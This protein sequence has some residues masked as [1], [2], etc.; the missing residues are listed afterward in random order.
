MAKR[1][2]KEVY[3]DLFRAYSVANNKGQVS[4]YIQELI[5]LPNLNSSLQKDH[6]V[7][8]ASI[9]DSS[10]NTVLAGILRNRKKYEEIYKAFPKADAKIRDSLFKQAF[11]KDYVL[12]DFINN[13][14]SDKPKDL[15]TKLDWLKTNNI[16][17][18]TGTKA[19]DFVQKLTSLNEAEVKNVLKSLD[20]LTA[21]STGNYSKF[22]S[23]IAAEIDAGT[24]PAS[25]PAGKKG[26][27]R[28]P[29]YTIA[30][31]DDW[32]ND[33]RLKNYKLLSN[34]G[35][36]ILDATKN[37]E[38]IKAYIKAGLSDTSFVSKVIQDVG[39]VSLNKKKQLF[40]SLT[41]N[42]KELIKALHD[43]SILA[44]DDAKYLQEDVRNSYIA[45]VKKVF[46]N[47]NATGKGKIAYELAKN[48]YLNKNDTEI[49]KYAINNRVKLNGQQNLDS[50]ASLITDQEVKDAF[51]AE[52]KNSFVSATDPAAKQ[53][54]LD[55]L[56]KNNLI[57]TNDVKVIE[58]IANNSKGIAAARKALNDPELQK[59]LDNKVY[60][61]YI[62]N[63]KW[64]DL[65]NDVKARSQYSYLSINAPDRLNSLDTLKKLAT[66]NN[67]NV[68][69]KAF[70]ER[71][72]KISD[73]GLKLEMEQR[74]ADASDLTKNPIKQ[75]E[76]NPFAEY[77]FNNN[78]NY[79]HRQ[80]YLNSL[81]A[82]E[83]VDADGKLK[84]A[85]KN[86][87]LTEAE[88]DSIRARA[89]LNPAVAHPH[90]EGWKQ[91]KQNLA[92]FY[93]DLGQA[94]KD[95]AQ[96]LTEFKK[97]L[98]KALGFSGGGNNPSNLDLGVRNYGNLT[99]GLLFGGAIGYPTEKYINEP[100]RETMGN[101][102]TGNRVWDTLTDTLTNPTNGVINTALIPG[103]M[104]GFNDAAGTGILG[105]TLGTAGGVFKYGLSP[106]NLGT[107]F[108]MAAANQGRDA[109][110]ISSNNAAWQALQSGVPWW[111]YGAT[112][113]TPWMWLPAA[114]SA[115]T[116]AISN[117]AMN[118]QTE[119]L[120]M[121]DTGK[122]YAAGADI[123]GADIDNY[124][125]YVFL[126][127]NGK[128]KDIYQIQQ[129]MIAKGYPMDS[130]SAQD[131]IDTNYMA[132]TPE[133]VK[134]VVNNHVNKDKD[135]MRRVERALT[136]YDENGNPTGKIKPAQETG[137]H[138]T[139]TLDYAQKMVTTS[140]K[141][142]GILGGLGRMGTLAL[143]GME[144][145]WN[146]LARG[147]TM[148]YKDGDPKRAMENWFAY[149]KKAKNEQAKEAKAQQ[150]KATSVKQEAEQQAAA[151]EAAQEQAAQ[152]VAAIQ[153][154]R[155]A[156]Q[157][158]QVGINLASLTPMGGQSA[159]GI[160]DLLAM[161]S[162]QQNPQ[163][164]VNLA[165]FA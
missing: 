43:N 89:N 55:Y 57:T 20:S 64:D 28:G 10:L 32:I 23:N 108:L 2:F 153:Q 40:G 83:I 3:N 88:I 151:Q 85:W 65:D 148:E 48:G 138:V 21:N 122:R 160:D 113:M 156:Y 101:A 14:K 159:S 68:A 87:G 77:E 29:K 30:G 165:N 73:P 155:Q 104:R 154:A 78:K 67:G 25:G 6:F 112:S 144:G 90:L 126:D 116:A 127:R 158:P 44:I 92:D 54:N 63:P 27:P 107:A 139:D 141:N 4:K 121:R 84:D 66:D 100:L 140:F 128:A 75:G 74:I 125:G 60:E 18:I 115:A 46:T 24:L 93:K 47:N 131:Y 34:Q 145:A 95:P 26:T 17:D 71:V 51:D 38:L 80:E 162:M 142:D 56:T 164:M 36:S 134:G 16:F 8:L 79:A 19:G 1:S 72:E 117:A 42:D 22:V 114:T 102:Q 39:S 86:K 137:N 37:V 12:D 136:F 98:G 163:G 82:D 53:R 106:Q 143:L 35:K 111:Q 157:T 132:Y 118:A 110:N 161:Y 124:K 147:N 129:E 59:A 123:V 15:I 49:F 96:H 45:E 76:T 133:F 94:G 31:I 103:A 5:K 62:N 70:K 135:W 105:R 33:Y 109:A 41:D 120:G 13:Y 81:N 99:K 91:A 150:P 97:N 61:E 11:T 9:K 130:K 7:Y 149:N 69:V 58:S 119:R 50:F 52:V 146:E 152:T